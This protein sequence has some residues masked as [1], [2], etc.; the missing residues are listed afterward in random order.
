MTKSDF[1]NFRK[2]I[3]WN[4]KEMANRLKVSEQTVNAYSKGKTPIPGPVCQLINEWKERFKL[5]G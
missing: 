4:K 2:Q 3:G 1:E 5:E